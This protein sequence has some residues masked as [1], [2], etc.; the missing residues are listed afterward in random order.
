MSQTP[1]TL[2]VDDQADN[3]IL[4][5]KI[6]RAEGHRTTLAASGEEALAKVREDNYDLILLDVMMP[7]LNGLEVTQRL[8]A[9][10]T[11]RY[12]PVILVT[13]K[14]DLA[15]VVEGLDAGADDYLTKPVER[16]ELLARV[17]SAL[18]TRALQQ[19]LRAAESEIKRSFEAL[20]KRTQEKEALQVQVGELRRQVAATGR[21]GE[22][23]GKSPAMAQVFERIRL[24]APT[25]ATVLIRGETGTGKEL[26]AKALHKASSRSEGPFMAINCG[27]L[28]ENLL[29]SELFGHEKGAFTGA[30]SQ[31]PGRFERAQGGTLF[32]DE[33]GDVP[34][35]MQVKLLRVIQ[36]REFERVGGT[37]TIRADVRLVA[38][39]HKDLETMVSKGEFRQDLYYRLNVVPLGLPPLRERTDDLPALARHLMA[40]AANF[41]SLELPEIQVDAMERILRH[42]WPG[43]VREL[44]NA[45]ERALVLSGG[46]AISGGHML[47]LGD[48]PGPV[49]PVGG[50][51]SPDFHLPFKLW[52]KTLLAHHERAYILEALRRN[53]GNMTA[54]ARQTG[55]DAKTFQ[56]KIREYGIKREEFAGR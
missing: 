38:A 19:S 1:H 6:L 26:V 46:G 3:A 30:S 56:R 40:K 54:A 8:K 33:I 44:E 9:H 55:V 22:M 12:I 7:G 42:R 29:E 5:K 51:A 37:D 23:I 52:K 25:E 50:A 32:L 36:E 27:A 15:S 20:V 28:P 18:R 17:R 11:H 13:A 24:V 41:H 43:N 39:T 53:E 21:F 45:L 35:S 2:I 48:G 16:R 47:G 31:K 10:D 14:A 34:M 49:A 4:L